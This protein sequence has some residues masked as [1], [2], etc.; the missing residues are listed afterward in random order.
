M[1]FGLAP[2]ILDRVLEPSE[3][4]EKVYAH[5]DRLSLAQ[6]RPMLSVDIPQSEAVLQLAFFDPFGQG[7]C[8][9]GGWVSDD[10]VDSNGVRFQ[11]DPPCQGL[12][13]GGCL[14]TA[15]AVVRKMDKKGQARHQGAI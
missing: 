11:V 1:D 7:L 12:P 10:G 8:R 5:L 3:V 6:P 9:D 2:R 14:Y 4:Q 15:P 13:Q